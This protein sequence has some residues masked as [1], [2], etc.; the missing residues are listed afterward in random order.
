MFCFSRTKC[1]D[2]K[3]FSTESL[4]QMQQL[5]VS[6]TRP[7]QPTCRPCALTHQKNNLSRYIKYEF[8]VAGEETKGFVFIISER[9]CATHTVRRVII[10]LV[11]NFP[12]NK[13]EA[14]TSSPFH[15]VPKLNFRR[16]RF[17]K[18]IIFMKP[19]AKT[20][21]CFIR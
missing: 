7:S 14:S 5:C 12:F 8:S 9:V 6:T 15:P 3:Y 1:S 19:N 2:A 20:E 10:F 17:S 11:D 21:R 4:E 18:I 13:L 16:E